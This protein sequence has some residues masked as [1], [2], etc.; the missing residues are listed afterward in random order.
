MQYEYE[1][2]LHDDSY[3]DL[4]HIFPMQHANRWTTE[5]YPIYKATHTF[6]IVLNKQNEMHL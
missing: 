4:R 6:I 1:Y 5:T 2:G 3:I